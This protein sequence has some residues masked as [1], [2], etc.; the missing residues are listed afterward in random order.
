MEWQLYFG[1]PIHTMATRTD[2]QAVL[3]AD[4][5]VRA[6]G[7]AAMTMPEAADAQRIDL[8]GKTMLPAFLDPHS[9][10]LACAHAM[11]Q[12]SLGSARS[13]DEL[14]A[15][16][17]DYLSRTHLPTGEWLVAR[18]F[19]PTMLREGKVPDRTELD[20]MVPNHPVILQ[21]KS[22]HVGVLNSLGLERM[23][24][25]P[26][27]PDPDGGR[28]ERE[29]GRLTGYLEENA[30]LSVLH[31]LPPPDW[32]QLLQ[33]CDRAQE[34]YASF[35]IATV[36]E[37]ML[38]EEMTGVYETLCRE[39]RL[40]LD[41]V[42]YAAYDAHRQIE[43]TLPK[44]TPGFRLGG[45]KIF[46]DG[47]PQSRTAWLR[48]PYVQGGCGYPVLR[49][50]QAD[51]AAME[52][53]ET[54]RQLIAHCNGDAAAEQFLQA[55]AKA[56]AK[57]GPLQRPVMIHAQ[58]VGLDQLPRLKGLGILPSF[59]VAHVYHWGDVHLENL[60]PARA[61]QISPAGSAGDLGLRY[62][63]HQDSPVIPPDMLE[64]VWCAANRITRAGAVLGGGERVSVYDALRAITIHAA[65]QYGE[66]DKK[67]SIAPGKD[68]SFVL[69]DRDPL[70]VPPAE[71]R[72]IR[73][74]ETICRGKTIYRAEPGK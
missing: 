61:A 50:E 16:L 3:A 17:C 66:E 46:L 33:A 42:G 51:L 35:G 6:V 13:F 18:D 24:I 28:I 4:G 68:A 2:A 71:L 7:P 8:Q 5:V 40:K 36:Q 64:T 67:G 44:E 56:Q 54:G 58:L 1:G 73:V 60:G 11:L 63:F 69:L 21:H 25:T 12:L 70:A 9:H 57:V 52:A 23:G 39:K 22:G 65:Y 47:S 20:R 32:Q 59:F 38:T 72:H 14:E 55:V 19:D 29:N 37:G 30:F 74:V 48:T 45:W 49:D 41:V 62:T 15:L 27:T 53:A 31:R 26:D 10:F 34:W 43:Q